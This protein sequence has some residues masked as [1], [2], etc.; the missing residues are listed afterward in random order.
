MWESI[1][2]TLVGPVTFVLVWSVLYFSCFATVLRALSWTV[3]LFWLCLIAILTAAHLFS[4]PV[5]FVHLV[6]DTVCLLVATAASVILSWEQR[7][8]IRDFSEDSLQ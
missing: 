1:Y 8:Q 5:H 3:G 2:L 6:W 7:Q 4:Y